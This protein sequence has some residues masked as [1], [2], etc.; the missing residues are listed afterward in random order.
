MR[1]ERYASLLARIATRIGEWVLRCTGSTAIRL[2]SMIMFPYLRLAFY[3]LCALI[4][5]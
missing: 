3:S 4:S 5:F 1:N 2:A